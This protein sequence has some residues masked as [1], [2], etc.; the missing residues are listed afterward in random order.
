[1][2]KTLAVV[3]P[4]SFAATYPHKL[5]AVFREAGDALTAHTV[6][7]REKGEWQEEEDE[8]K[9]VSHILGDYRKEDWNRMCSFAANITKK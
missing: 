8:E 3:T 7:E 4:Y 1:M 6:I 9:E 2:E 5:A